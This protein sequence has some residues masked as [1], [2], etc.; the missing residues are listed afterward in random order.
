MATRPWTLLQDRAPLQDG[1][2]KCFATILSRDN[3]AERARESTHNQKRLPTHEG[4]E[5]DGPQPMYYTA[6]QYLSARPSG[7]AY[8]RAAEAKQKR[9]GT[10]QRADETEMG[11]NSTGRREGT[12]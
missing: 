6:E 10:K 9:S 7:A 11:S 5:V 1:N 8:M 3:L 4:A 2:K 12:R